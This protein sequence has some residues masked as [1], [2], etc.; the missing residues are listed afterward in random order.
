MRAF[1]VGALMRIREIAP[2][3]QRL[4]SAIVPQ[5]PYT[6]RGELQDPFSRIVAIKYF[7]KR[8]S[9]GLLDDVSHDLPYEACLSISCLQR[10]AGISM[11][12]DKETVAT[13]LVCT[14]HHVHLRI[15]LPRP[16]G[17]K[18]PAWFCL[19]IFEER[20]LL[21]TW[22]PEGQGFLY[23]IW[24]WRSAPSGCGPVF[25]TEINIHPWAIDSSV[26]GKRQRSGSVRVFM[27][28]SSTPPSHRSGDEPYAILRDP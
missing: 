3:W 10:G 1:K 12:P 22:A 9:I 27:G 28:A 11:V 26:Q 13:Y 6:R 7:T 25:Y 21:Q 17:Y 19:G 8:P 4:L 5:N 15:P 2:Q 24:P 20:A 16:L 23:R 18:E 14:G